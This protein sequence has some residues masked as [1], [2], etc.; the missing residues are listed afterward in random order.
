MLITPDEW[1]VL[2]YLKDKM[3]AGRSPFENDFC[4]N[5]LRRMIN[6]SDVDT[7]LKRT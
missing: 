7:H 5:V 3:A 2:N 1:K 6:A 4:Y